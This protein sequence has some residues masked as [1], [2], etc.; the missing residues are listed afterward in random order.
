MDSFSFQ[1]GRGMLVKVAQGSTSSVY[2]ISGLATGTEAGAAITL[3]Q[4]C[5]GGQDIVG[6]TDAL[7]GKHVMYVFGETFKQIQI[8]GTIYIK[9]CS[10]F[11]G[12]AAVN[13]FFNSNRVSSRKSSVNVSVGSVKVGMYVT[14]FMLG[15]AD[16]T[17]NTITFTITGYARPRK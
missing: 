3:D 8:S 1:A 6:P 7:G 2:S 12:L 15:Q 11:D 5:I 4:I 16:P 10:G 17:Y 14:D 9:N 13:S